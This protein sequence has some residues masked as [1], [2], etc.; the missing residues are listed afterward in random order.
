MMQQVKGQGHMRPNIDL[1][2]AEA[3]FW[4]PFG[5]VAVQV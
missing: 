5:Q 2:L 4:T 1:G 3:S